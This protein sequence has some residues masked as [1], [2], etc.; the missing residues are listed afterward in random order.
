MEREVEWASRQFYFVMRVVPFPGTEGACLEGY[1]SDPKITST[2]MGTRRRQVNNALVLILTVSLITPV[3]TT[4]NDP[5]GLEIFHQADHL[6]L[7]PNRGTIRC[8]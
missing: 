4:S 2:G 3:T 7:E 1:A 6:T 8:N 5:L